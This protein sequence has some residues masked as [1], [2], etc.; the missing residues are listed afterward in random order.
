MN[1]QCAM[2]CWTDLWD[3]WLRRGRQC[4]CVADGCGLWMEGRKDALEHEWMT[5][6]IV[7]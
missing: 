2:S 5:L 4:L 3:C 6:V 1:V 7:R